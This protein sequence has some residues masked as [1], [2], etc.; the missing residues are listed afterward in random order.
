[1]PRYFA[2]A[3]FS[4]FAPQP[5]KN[6]TFL[7]LLFQAMLLSPAAAQELDYHEQLQE[8]YCAIER[9]DFARAQEIIR[10]ERQRNPQNLVPLYL[11]NS[12]ALLQYLMTDNEGSLEHYIDGSDEHK[13]RVSDASAESPLYHFLLGEMHL[14]D[15]I[16]HLRASSYMKAG[17]NL[18]KAYSHLQKNRKLHPKFL[19]TEKSLLPMEAGL[20]AVPQTYQWLLNLFGYSGELEQ[21]VQRYDEW[22]ARLEQANRWTCYLQEA[23]L[24]NSYLH[25]HLLNKEEQ[26]WKLTQEATESFSTNPLAALARANMAMRLK[27][28]EEALRVLRPHTKVE[29]AISQLYYLHGLALLQQPQAIANKASAPAEQMLRKFLHSYNGTSYV[30]DAWLKV[31]WAEL[32]KGKPQEAARL[33][34]QIR[35]LPE[36]QTEEDRQALQEAKQPRYY[37]SHPYLLRARLLYDG[38]YYQEALSLLRESLDMAFEL[39][40]SAR[41]EFHYRLGRVYDALGQQEQA[42]Q[43]YQ[44]ASA[45]PPDGQYYAPASC[46]YA[47]LLYEE[48]GKLAKAEQLY[49]A[50]LGFDDYPYK[51]SFDHRAT[52][53][54]KRI[55]N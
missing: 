3:Q 16:A 36:P 28:N 31:A 43:Y 6:A 38:G 24:I 46:Y 45:I 30:H 20:G 2:K 50:C 32:L 37:Q 10:Q 47:G 39:P 18:N 9:Y 8:A 5:M 48:Q 27:K 14:Q 44:A 26:A 12:Q 41:A 19:L 52:A 42:I 17:W 22:M 35:E 54:L 25:L 23:R 15:A 34:A 21:S 51:R 7:L 55:R 49:R 33:M 4:T 13:D 29:G 40:L 11:E 53:A 1:M